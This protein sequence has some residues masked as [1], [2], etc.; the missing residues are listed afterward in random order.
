[1]ATFHNQTA[2]RGKGR[3]LAISILSLLVT[4]SPFFL[5]PKKTDPVFLPEAERKN[6]VFRDGRLFP[7]HGETF[8]T[9]IMIERYETGLLKSRSAISNGLI[10]GVSEGRYTNGLLQVRE[11]FKHGTS[12]GVREKWDEKGNKMSE[13]VI[14]DGKLEGLFRRWHENGHLAEQIEM[15]RG[16]PNGTALAYFPSGFLKTEAKLQE[17]RLIEQRSWKDGESTV[18]TLS[19]PQL[20]QKVSSNI[21]LH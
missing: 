1:V 4:A 3:A 17:G 16:V 5:G 13:A 15:R 14:V 19:E 10:E 9:G 8:F 12:N 11:H 7:A 18:L 2:A 20:H 21:G 6:L